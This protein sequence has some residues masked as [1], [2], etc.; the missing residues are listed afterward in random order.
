MLVKAQ[1][2]GTP[3]VG[4]AEGDILRLD[5]K[6]WLTICVDKTLHLLE[7]EWGWDAWSN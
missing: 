6:E 2:H 5:A 1:A 3:W 4:T 7:L